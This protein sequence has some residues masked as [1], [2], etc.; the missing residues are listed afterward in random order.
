MDNERKPKEAD[1]DPPQGLQLSK[2][3][4][5]LLT[6]LVVGILV[7]A[8]VLTQ[9]VPRGEYLRDAAGA[10]MNGTYARLPDFKLP[11]WHVLTAPVE[12]FLSPQALTGVGILLFIVLIGGTFLILE[13]SRVIAYMMQVIVRKYET[14]KY[15][16]LALV[17]L[18]CMA[19]GSV[20]GILEESI[21]LVPLAA[22]IALALGWDSLT[23]LGFSLVAVAMGYSAATFNPFNVG[24]VQA[25]AGLPAFSGLGYR[26][27]V[28]AVIYAVLL[29]FLWLH[30]RRVEKAP[31]KSLSYRTDQALKERFAAT[32][33]ET[34]ALT[35]NRSLAKATKIFVGCVS[36]VLVCAVLSF[37]LQALPG[38]P[39]E[40]KS[41][42]GYLPMLGMALLFTLGGIFAG[43]A[44]GLGGK[45]LGKT[46]WQGVKTVAPIAP[47]LVLVM[48][49]TWLLQKGK[50][51][52]TVLFTVYTH[53]KGVSPFVALQAILALTIVLEFFIGSGSA[54]AFL[55]MPVLL[56]LAKLLLVSSQ[57]VTLAFTLGDGVCNIL[58]PTSGIMIIAIGLI[59]VSYI[60][61]L[62]WTWKLFL[63]LFATSIG[64][65]WVAQRIGY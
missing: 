30:A 43:K 31:Q 13:K 26:L 51:I 48:S 6:G 41:I 14:K 32:R 45:A 2:K 12:V 11:L 8:G 63:A 59:D 18:V 49:V 28:F 22:S 3:T 35:Q 9:V 38:V 64:L 57:S 55:M 33:E 27:V 65:L 17:T 4:V 39:K 20:V 5:L 44:A 56:P 60:K 40:V 50:I 54:K 62:R 46:F 25:M 24:I 36:G 15:A 7:F 1:K 21:T 42:A 47:L 61:F 19:L 58:Y 52:D 34:E 16:L 53:V 29:A 23:G 37:A 10:V